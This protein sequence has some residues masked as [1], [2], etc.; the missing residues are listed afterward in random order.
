M[1][2][3][4]DIFSV[5][6]VPDLARYEHDGGMWRNKEQIPVREMYFLQNGFGKAN[7][8]LGNYKC[9]GRG[10]SVLQLLIIFN[11]NFNW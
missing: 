9:W 5:G 4:F 8:T 6:D 3:S 7:I 11:L 2:E 1:N 10:Q